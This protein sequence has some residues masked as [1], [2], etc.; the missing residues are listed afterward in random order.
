MTIPPV[1]GRTFGL[2]TVI[3]RGHIGARKIGG[4]P[5]KHKGW[6][7]RCQC[8]RLITTSLERLQLGYVFSCNP[9]GRCWEDVKR[10]PRTASRRLK[11][12]RQQKLEEARAFAAESH[13]SWEKQV[14]SLGRTKAEAARLERK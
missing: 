6:T 1:L 13:S 11:K 9:H 8:G 12:T 2:L 5:T 7:C 10:E 4:T 14:R 3:R